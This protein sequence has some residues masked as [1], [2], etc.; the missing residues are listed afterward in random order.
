MSL[1]ILQIAAI[2]P[3]AIYLARW[4]VGLRH[5]NAQNWNSL[6]ARLQLDWSGR[7]LSVHFLSKEGLDTSPEEIWERMHGIRGIRAMY[8]NAGVMLE[9]V[10]YAARNIEM[11]NSNDQVILETLRCDAMQI[12]S[13]ALRVLARDTFNQASESVRSSAFHV[14][15]MYT[16]MAA[17]MAQLLQ[18]SAPEIL[19]EFVAAM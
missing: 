15:S 17:R 12:R 6:V 16:G 19:P 10:D 4:R 1:P 7:E 2:A 3:V 8:L 5:R 14:A 13:E 9:M 18:V 11:S